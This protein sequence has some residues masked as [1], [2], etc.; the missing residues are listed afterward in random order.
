MLNGHSHHSRAVCVI[1]SPFGST[2]YCR[3]TRC[4]WCPPRQ[5]ASSTRQTTALTVS[6]TEGKAISLSAQGV[7]G[8]KRTK[9][10]Q[11]RR[12]EVWSGGR[13]R[14]DKQSRVNNGLFGG[15]GRQTDRRPGSHRSTVFANKTVVRTSLSLGNLC[16]PWVVSFRFVER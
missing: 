14:V 2:A 10:N 4:C 12:R 6:D 5:R 1:S 8:T 13:P 16:F 7:R 11:E 15:G 3:Y 9:N